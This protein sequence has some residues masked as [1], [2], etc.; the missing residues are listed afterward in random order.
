MVNKATITPLPFFFLKGATFGE[1][2][3]LALL[4]KKSCKSDSGM[5]LLF[6]E[7]MNS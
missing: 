6:F 5:E 4:K 3:I 1:R 2:D 7:F